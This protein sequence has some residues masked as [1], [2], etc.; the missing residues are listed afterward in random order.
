MNQINR[1]QV[2]PGSAA[3]A[4][5]PALVLRLCTWLFK[6]PGASPASI[7]FAETCLSLQT[8]VADGQECRGFRSASCDSFFL[9]P[10]ANTP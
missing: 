3:F 9:D 2:L 4:A 8:Q 5:V 6:H 7:S 10:H 1:R